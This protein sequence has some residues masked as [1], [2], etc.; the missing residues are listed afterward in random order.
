MPWVQRTKWSVLLRPSQVS[1]IFWNEVV[2]YEYCGMHSRSKFV[3]YCCCKSK[4][5][6]VSCPHSVIF[7]LAF[8]LRRVVGAAAL[9]SLEI[10]HDFQQYLIVL[11]ASHQDGTKQGRK[12]SHTTWSLVDLCAAFLWVQP[13]GLAMSIFRGAPAR[14]KSWW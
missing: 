8:P 10:P 13:A 11:L 1:D 2:V 14:L 3:S 4:S 12:C 6:L 9:G 5:V 7:T